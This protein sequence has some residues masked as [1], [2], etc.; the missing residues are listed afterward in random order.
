MTFTRW[1]AQE[2]T[3]ADMR[4]DQDNARG[5]E[6]TGWRGDGGLG[7]GRWKARE[8]EMVCWGMRMGIMTKRSRG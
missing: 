2:I 5:D 4:Y 1:V 6:G 8:G 3:P 7:R